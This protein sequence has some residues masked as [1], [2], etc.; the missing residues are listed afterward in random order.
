MLLIHPDCFILY[1]DISF[2]LI[3]MPGFT[4]MIMSNVTLLKS[5]TDDTY[6][7]VMIAELI[8]N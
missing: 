2:F 5:T 3:I 6:D 4:G 8:S 7:G 1:N